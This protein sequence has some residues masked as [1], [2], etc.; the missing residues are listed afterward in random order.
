MMTSFR[1]ISSYTNI[2]CCSLVSALVFGCRSWKVRRDLHGF[3]WIYSLF[4]KKIKVF[5]GQIIRLGWWGSKGRE[6]A[7]NINTFCHLVYRNWRNRWGKMR[8]YPLILDIL[9]THVAT[10]TQT[11]YKPRTWYS[12][13]N[14]SNII[15]RVNESGKGWLVEMLCC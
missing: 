4:A 7:K 9:P 5:A 14:Q 12:G 6:P 2:P 11:G 1:R 10:Y 8:N 15:E 3:V 13:S